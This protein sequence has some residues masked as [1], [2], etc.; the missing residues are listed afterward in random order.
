[1]CC[2]KEN[3]LISD[4]VNKGMGS[5]VAKN[6][7]IGFGVGAIAGV[8]DI[9]LIYLV[10]PTSSPWL[11]A[12]AGIAWVLFGWIV[13]STSS[14]LPPLWHGI[15]ITLLINIPWYINFSVLQGDVTHLPPLIVQGVVF[16]AL[17]GWAKKRWG[18]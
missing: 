10:E 5:A 14:G 12:Q 7:K 3:Y 16:G 1:L 9:I 11:L 4:Y 2:R 17:F 18:T 6:W 13:V 15:V 8:L